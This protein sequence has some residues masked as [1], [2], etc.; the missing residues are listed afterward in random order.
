MKRTK[1]V[2]EPHH[3]AV[4]EA[5]NVNPL[6]GKIV[7]ADFIPPTTVRTSFTRTTKTGV[8]KG[9]HYPFFQKLIEEGKYTQKEL[10]EMAMTEFP[11]L[12]KSTFQTVLTDCRNPKYNKLPKLVLRDENGILY[13]ADDNQ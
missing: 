9:A 7:N 13:F 10:V 8:V 6:G 1:K 3:V 5:N 12:S 11:H 4:V 2:P